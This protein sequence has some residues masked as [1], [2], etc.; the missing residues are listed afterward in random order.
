M[1]PWTFLQYGLYAILALIAGAIVAER[2]PPILTRA[3]EV[4]ETRV[5]VVLLGILGG[6]FY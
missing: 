5:A 3:T 6:A 1:I 4:L 2:A